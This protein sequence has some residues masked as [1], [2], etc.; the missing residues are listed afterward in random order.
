MSKINQENEALNYLFLFLFI[1]ILILKIIAYII[2]KKLFKK[3]KL[4][5]ILGPSGA[6]KDTLMNLIKDKHPNKF[7]KCVSYTTRSPRKG[8]KQGEN[9]YFIS[10]EEF[11]K[12]DSEQKIIGKFEKYGNYYGSSIDLIY[13]NLNEHKDKIIYFD[14]N[15]ETAKKTLEIKNLSFNYIAIVPPSIEELEKRL[16]G[17]KSENQDS[18]HQR[19]TYAKTELEMIKKADFLNYV[20]ENDDLNKASSQFESCLKKLYPGLLKS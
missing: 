5:I 2:C 19:I 14:Y 6:G 15:I 12:L 18:L 3:N 7:F 11:Q 13:K 1:Y 8:E 17:R 10:K 4:L 9:Y 16:I 20:I